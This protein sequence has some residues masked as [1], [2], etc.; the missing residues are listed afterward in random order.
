MQNIILNTDSYKVSMWKQYPPETDTVYSYIESRGNDENV[1]E[2]I[3]FGIQAFIQKYIMPRVTAEQVDIA[4]ELWT[5]NGMPF[6]REGWMYIV[7]E[8]DGVLPVKIKA[9]PEGMPIPLH[10]VMVTIENTDPKCFW[11]TTW[12][13]TAML[14]AIW[15]PTSVATLSYSIKKI[16]A[17]ALLETGDIG[18]LPFMLNDFG[19]RGATSEETS[20]LGGMA[21]LINFLGSDT[22][23]GAIAAREFYDEPMAAMSIP[24]MEH[25]T[26]TSWGKDNE[27]DAYL[28]ML[29]Q[30][31]DS[32]LIAVVSDSYD[33]WNAIQNIWGDELKKDVMAFKGML[34]IRP[35]S[36]DP[37]EV[38]R[39]TVKELDK[40]F[41]STVNDKGYKVLNHVRVI[42]GDGVNQDS[43]EVILHYLKKDGY[44]A[45]N[46]AFG[47]GGALLQGVNRDSFKF[48]MKCSAIRD[49]SGVWHDVFKD[50][51][52]DK[53]KKSKKG[54]FAVVGRSG[55]GEYTISSINEEDMGETEV[56]LLQV[57]YEDGVA[58][59]RTEFSEVRNRANDYFVKMESA[60]KMGLAWKYNAER[61]AA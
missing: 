36:G 61:N 51:I 37:V 40:V 18:N 54:R 5:A 45:D 3:N 52:T 46:M 57:V 55:F 34:V 10:T 13:E 35:D 26:V 9:L 44:S 25:S 16:M 12:L 2:I 15:Y 28:N 38:V 14:R 6:N 49:T 41:G 19:A 1:K 59:N 20:G 11:L 43:I 60:Y 22:M 29:T 53:V 47:M 50:P 27:S 17:K 32:P 4:E 30:Y 8:L 39:R 21:H 24:A 42:Q 58:Y 33:I 31:K 23:S 56:D 48:A 7:N